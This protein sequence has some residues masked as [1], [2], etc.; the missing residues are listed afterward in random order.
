MSATAALEYR[1][2]QMQRRSSIRENQ[3]M[4]TTETASWPSSTM[5]LSSLQVALQESTG[6]MDFPSIE[7]SFDDN[8]NVNNQV[9]NASTLQGRSS[10]MIPRCKSYENLFTCCVS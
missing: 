6:A 8:Q 7:W 9:P 1:I 2:E 3:C 10:G 4:N 5:G